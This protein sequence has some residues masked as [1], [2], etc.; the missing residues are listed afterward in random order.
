VD[1]TLPKDD[2]MPPLDDAAI[3]L[4]AIYRSSAVLADQDPPQQLDD[5]HARS[6]TV[7]ARVPHVSLSD[8]SNISSL[9]AAAGAGFALLAENGLDRWQRAAAEVGDFLGAEVS[10]WP[11]S[12]GS[13]LAAQDPTAAGSGWTGAAL[14]RPDG[15]IA[16]KPGPPAA[17]AA[18]QL[19]S[20]M[21]RMLS[22]DGA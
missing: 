14:I 6:W 16:W 5:P 15:V 19:V 18:G 7:G 11:V 3:E 21:A 10:V 17:E 2:L 9:D 13:Q 1:T 12:A 22:R 8:G 20:V 4:G